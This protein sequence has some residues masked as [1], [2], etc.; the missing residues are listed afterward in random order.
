MTE[1]PTFNPAHV[2]DGIQALHGTGFDIEL[3]ESLHRQVALLNRPGA[4]RD[5]GLNY[6]VGLL[7]QKIALFWNLFPRGGIRPPLS[8]DQAQ[9]E[10]IL[11][12]DFIHDELNPALEMLYLAVHHEIL[13]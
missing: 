7:A 1:I 3:L 5:R 9:L 10:V 4:T 13:N 2:R 8:F 12:Q 11:E 6:Q